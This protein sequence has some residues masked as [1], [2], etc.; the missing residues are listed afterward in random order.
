MSNQ[1]RTFNENLAILANKDGAQ[2]SPS[3]GMYYILV[4][5][6]NVL[7]GEQTQ[8]LSEYVLWVIIARE[9]FSVMLNGMDLYSII[10]YISNHISGVTTG[11]SEYDLISF[12]SFSDAST[13]STYLRPDGVSTYLRP[14]GVSTYLRP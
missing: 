13:A 5:W 6:A 3:D 2:S 8:G 10:K 4:K 11:G 12:A 14:D 1:G 9:K 7:S